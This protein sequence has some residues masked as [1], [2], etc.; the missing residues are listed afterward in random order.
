MVSPDRIIAMKD[1]V[2]AGDVRKARILVKAGVPVTG[3]EPYS[4]LCLAAMHSIE[5][6]FDFLVANGAPIDDP[7]VLRSAVGGS[8][9]QRRPSTKIVRAI[10]EA[11]EF[12]SEV[13][14]ECLRFASATENV[15]VVRM[16]LDRGADPNGQDPVYKFFPLGNAVEAGH[17][18]VV[19]ALLDA[20]A[21]PTMEFWDFEENALTGSRLTLVDVALRNGF[22]E[23]AKAL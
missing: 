11:A 22:P 10:L 19:L 8:P 18:E 21:D 4:F 14:T 1:A 23:I 12:D 2:F 20:G 9:K 7:R 5:E 17:L 3:G 6:M 15:D 16:L 13:L